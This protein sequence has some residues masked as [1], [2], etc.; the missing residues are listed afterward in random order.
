[1]LL[2]GVGRVLAGLLESAWLVMH[3]TGRPLRAVQQ[4][5]LVKSAGV[6]EAE[7]SRCGEDQVP[8]GPQEQIPLWRAWAQVPVQAQV[9]APAQMVLPLRWE[10]PVLPPLTYWEESRALKG[11]HSGLP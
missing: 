1:L 7:T 6:E 11:G 2:V 10:S 4:E 9:P 5:E 8:G 3:S